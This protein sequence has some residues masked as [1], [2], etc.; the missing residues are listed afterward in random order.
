MLY[1]LYFIHLLRNTEDVGSISGTGIYQVGITPLIGG[2]L[3]LGSS[4]WQVKEPQGRW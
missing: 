2:P 3:S 4:Q 1:I